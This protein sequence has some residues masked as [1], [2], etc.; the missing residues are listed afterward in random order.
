M[1]AS[2]EQIELVFESPPN[3]LWDEATRIIK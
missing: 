2:D 1:L 3:T